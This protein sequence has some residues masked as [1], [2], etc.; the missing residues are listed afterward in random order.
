MPS[1]FT[2]FV[3]I[4]YCYLSFLGFSR[5]MMTSTKE[6]ALS[7][8]YKWFILS[9]QIH[10]NDY[11]KVTDKALKK[12]AT[13]TQLHILSSSQEPQTSKRQRNPFLRD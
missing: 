5:N 9:K 6:E 1:K 10:N 8:T 11:M 7:S 12:R 3:I 4:G 13:Y 2:V